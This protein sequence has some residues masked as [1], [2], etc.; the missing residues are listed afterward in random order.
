MKSWTFFHLIQLKKN[1][2]VKIQF[3]NKKDKLLYSLLIGKKRFEANSNN[4]EQVVVGR[5]VRVP[6]QKNIILTDELFNVVNFKENDWLYDR[7]ISISNI[8]SI[9][10]AKESDIE[11]ILTRNTEEEGFSL[12][13]APDYKNLNKQKIESITSSLNNLKFNSVAN[14]KLSYAETGLTSPVSLTV[15]TF[16]GNKY[17]LLIGKIYDNSRYVKLSIVTDK[18]TL[19]EKQLN[20]QDLF[21]KWIYLIDLN[22]IDPFLS[23][24]NGILKQEKRKRVPT[25]IYSRPIS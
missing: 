20:Q 5:Y 7:D 25:N 12:K 15:S 16:N 4:K 10:L 11:W 19:S 18:K 1:R 9:Q 2:A 22:R 13:G 6:S 23:S 3:F 17:K 14:N 24:K 21:R 8:K